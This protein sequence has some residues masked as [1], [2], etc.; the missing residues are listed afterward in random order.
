MRVKVFRFR[1]SNAASRPCTGDIG[2]KWF[3]KSKAELKSNEYIEDTINSFLD[4]VN[5]A[6]DIKVNTVDVG[7]HNNGRGNTVDLVY[8]VLYE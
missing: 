8:T 4:K 7:F 6:I 3:D 5:R 1:V 2:E